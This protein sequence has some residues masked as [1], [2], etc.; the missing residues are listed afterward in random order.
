VFIVKYNSIAN[1]DSYIQS[2]RRM[3]GEII[4][5][6]SPIRV[7]YEEK[8]WFVVR[9]N[10][11]Y[12]PYVRSAVF[13]YGVPGDLFTLTVSGSILGLIRSLEVRNEGK[14]YAEQL[15]QAYRAQ[16]KVFRH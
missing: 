11:R 14:S 5:I 6:K 12:L 4:K 8:T 16:K 15:R 13:M 7:I 10:H 3:F 1:A 2:L 9:V